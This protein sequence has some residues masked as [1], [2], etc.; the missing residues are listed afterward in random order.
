V[1]FNSNRERMRKELDRKDTIYQCY[2]KYP[3]ECKDNGSVKLTAEE[4]EEYINAVDKDDYLKK[5]GKCFG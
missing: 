2:V 3:K 4:M 1:T 5:I